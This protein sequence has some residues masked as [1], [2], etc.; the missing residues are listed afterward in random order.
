MSLN[1]LSIK[2]TDQLKSFIKTGTPAFFH[3]SKTSTVIPYDKIESFLGV[4]TDLTMADLSSIPGEMQVSNDGNLI[5]RGAVSWSEARIFLAEHG[6]TIMTAPTE[7]LALILAG[8]A[9]S[10][11][12]ERCFSFGNMR[13]QIISIKYINYNGEEVLLSSHQDF[14]SQ[15]LDISGYQKDFEIYKDLKNAPFPRLLKQTDLMIG[16]EGQLGVITEAEIKTIKSYTTQH[17]FLLIPKWEDD[18]TAHLEIVNKIQN[19]RKEVILC[20]HIDSNSFNYLPSEERPNK[21]LDAVFFEINTENFE[22]FYEEFICGLTSIDQDLVFELSGSKFHQLRASIP[23]AVFEKNSEMGVVKMGTDVQVSIDNFESLMNIY[24]KFSNLGVK[25][26]LF[27]HF[28]DA[29]LH[30]NFMPM[31][32]QI[33]I[34]ADVLQEMYGSVKV[35]NASPFAEHGIGI[36]KQKFIKPFWNENQYSTFKGL[37]NQHDPKN[38]FFP[39]GYMNLI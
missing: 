38:Q 37:K 28:G 17:L 35:L 29:H 33:Q 19:Y 34:C 12:G 14:D 16:T 2:T 8:L 11:T 20:E 22:S 7:D 18:L 25:Y 23:R 24:Q 1:H 4:D 32:E 6:R 27:G 13:S 21:N 15:D 36:I 5:V 30:F 9:T 31:P 39:Q 10:C 3:S 26:N